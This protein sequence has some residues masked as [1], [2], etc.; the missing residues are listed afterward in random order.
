MASKTVSINRA[1]AL[2]LWAAVVARR[3][4]FDT[5]EA[6]SLAGAVAG[7]D[8]YSKGRWLGLFKPEEE[9]PKKAREKEPGVRFRVELLG[10][11]V[12]VRNTGDGVRAIQRGKAVDPDGVERYLD[13][14]FGDDLK[15]VRSAMEKL[16]KA[17]KPKELARDPY[18]LYERFRPDIPAGKRGWGA[19]GDL[20]LGLIEGLAREKP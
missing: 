7:L 12:P 13:G 15:A 17:Y 1:P 18:S 10:R 4:G 16:A 2:T 9:K 20:D 6:L 19:E 11:A 8:A 5:N 14:K 3:L